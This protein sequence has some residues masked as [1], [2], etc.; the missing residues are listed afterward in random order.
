MGFGCKWHKRIE[1]CLSLV[2]AYVIINGPPTME[3]DFG[4]GVRQ[5]DPLSLF[6]FIIAMEG[7]N[8]TMKTG[9]DK[10][11]F[12]GVKNPGNGPLPSHLFYA[13]DVLF[14]GD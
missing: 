13:D 1:G 9:C 4:R 11:L 12:N 14:F 7:L 10:G 6:L 3:F 2:R 5:R 8:V